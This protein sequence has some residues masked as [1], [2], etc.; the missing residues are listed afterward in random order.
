MKKLFIAFGLLAIIA[1]SPLAADSSDLYPVRVEV[2]KIFAHADGY[3]VVYN[4]G[5]SGTAVAYLPMRWL[6]PGGKAQLVAATDPSYPYLVV[7][8]KQGVLDHL[9]LYVQES[10]KDESWGVLDAAAGKGV[11]DK[12]EDVKLEF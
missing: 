11:F 9:R 2:V 1:L 5:N 3:V 6:V 12:I 10:F 8:Y 7:F 4:K